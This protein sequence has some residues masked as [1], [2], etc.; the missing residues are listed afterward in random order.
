MNDFSFQS[1]PVVTPT[2]LLDETRARRNIRTMAARAA[3]LGLTFRPHFKTHQAAEIGEWFRDEDV[4]AITVSSVAMAEYFANHGWRDITIA[5][6]CNVREIDGINELAR[7]VDL[8]VLLDAVPV[9]AY[10]AAQLSHSVR[11]WVE[12][13]PGYRRSGAPWSDDALLA[14]LA[15]QIE[16]ASQ[17]RFQGVLCH[18]GN[19]YGA[20]S[21]EEVQRIHAETV[22]RMVAARDTLG[23]ASGR[24]D[25]QISVGD[26]PACSMLDDL[27]PVDEI[28]P[29][30]F[31]FYDLTQLTIGACAVDEI[32]VAVA[33]P[34][35]GIYPER[36]ELVLY[37]GA[38]HLSK[39]AL[40]LGSDGASFGRIAP[41]TP[42]GWGQPFPETD[43]RSVSQE[44]GIVRVA[45]SA[46]SEVGG[47]LQIGDLVAVL[48]VHSC[49]TANLL[50]RYLTLQGH[51]IEMAPIP[52]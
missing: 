17:L 22:E 21:R 3:R 15:Q 24:G 44:H 46:W 25:L 45:D 20:R 48:P 11:V 13:D 4:T 7:R 36:R 52:R 37:G 29:G 5:F 34:V 35:V 26:T 39:D 40:A 19:T 47:T 8:G 12:V 32:A 14:A 49:L 18:A 30:N 1:A 27:G 51:V 9:V 50:K 38:V 42:D 2:L 16:A 33:C 43:L 23:I 41:L 31:V 6:P 10:L 28:R